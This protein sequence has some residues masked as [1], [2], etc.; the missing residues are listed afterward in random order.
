M[1]YLR[2]CFV[3][4]KPLGWVAQQCEKHCELLKDYKQNLQWINN[5]PLHQAVQNL[6]LKDVDDNVTELAGE[7]LNKADVPLDSSPMALYHYHFYTMVLCYHFNDYHSAKTMIKRL[8]KDIWM[9]GVAFFVP[10]RILYTGLV[11]TGLCRTSQRQ[12]FKYRSRAQSAMKHLRGWASKG[13]LSCEYMS[14]L[15]QAELLACPVVGKVNF[16]NVL[17]LYDKAIASVT[18]L[19]ILH[20]IALANELVGMFAWKHGGGGSGLAGSYMLEAQRYYAEWGS[21]AKVQDVQNRFG[22]VLNMKGKQSQLPSS[23]VRSVGTT[24]TVTQDEPSS[25]SSIR[26]Q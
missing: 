20:H 19:G 11:Y 22:D 3:A 7:H 17:G 23:L 18:E 2:R 6:R 15:L 14:Y 12:R 1:E 26:I 16:S 10:T 13:V 4:G 8:P 24:V 21:R 9:S 5:A 25:T